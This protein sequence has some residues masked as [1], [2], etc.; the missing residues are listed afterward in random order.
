M[1]RADG[2]MPAYPAIKRQGSMGRRRQKRG[3]HEAIKTGKRA[4]VYDGSKSPRSVRPEI[5]HRHLP[6]Q[7]E[8]GTA[9]EEANRDERTGSDFDHAGNAD[10]R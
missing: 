8:G 1:I 7:D 5:R 9:G 2:L 4:A 3:T 6:R 10:Q